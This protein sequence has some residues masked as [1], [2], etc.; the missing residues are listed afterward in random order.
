VLTEILSA[1]SGFT[2]EIIVVDDCSRDE[3]VA[4]VMA[5]VKKLTVHRVRLL[6]LEANHGKGGAIRKAV[7]RAEG[8][9]ILFADADNAT[10]IR[11]V[12]KLEQAMDEAKA[13][14]VVVCGSRAHLEEEAIATRHPLRNV[15]MHGFHHIVAT[16]CVRSVRDTQCGFKL[17]DREAARLLFVPMHI[18][19]WA[20]DVELLYLAEARKLLVKEVAV[21]WHEV[22]GSKLS[23]VSASLTMLR[24]LV[25]IR[26]CY[27]VGLWT[28]DDGGFRLALKHASDRR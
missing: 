19:R 26:L 3:T 27:T 21:Q 7:M 4:I 12:A 15:L 28:V 2:Y 14:G 13:A 8:Q 10:N 24:E 9:R 1:C 16:L 18:E 20:F 6:R 5:E 23:V 25:L 11:D 17:F 22:P